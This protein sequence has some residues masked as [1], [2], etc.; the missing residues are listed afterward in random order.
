MLLLFFLTLPLADAVPLP[1]AG[2]YRG[3]WK[4]STGGRVFAAFHGIRYAQPPTGLLRFQDPVLDVNVS[5]I[6]GDVP[7]CIQVNFIDDDVQGDEDCLFLNVY[8][9]SVTCDGM[10]PRRCIFKRIEQVRRLRA[11]DADG[12]RCRRRH[13]QLPSR[14]S[15]VREPGR[16]GI[17][18]RL[19]SQGPEG[20]SRLGHEKHRDVRRRPGF[21]HGRGSQRRG[22][23]SAPPRTPRR[24]IALSG[25]RYSPWGLSD[26]F[27]VRNNTKRLFRGL[28]CTDLACLKRADE[29]DLILTAKNSLYTWDRL[30]L[31]YRPVVDGGLIKTDP[32]SGGTERNFSLLIGVT[33]DEADFLSVFLQSWD[34]EWKNTMFRLFLDEIAMVDRM[35]GPEKKNALERIDEFYWRRGPDRIVELVSDSSFLFPATAEA[36]GHKGDLHAFMFAYKSRLPY[37]LGAAERIGHRVAHGD[38]L[39]FLFDSRDCPL[40]D[41]SSYK[42]IST[43][44]TDTIV[45]FIKGLDPGLKSWKE[46]QEIFSVKDALYD[47]EEYKDIDENIYERMHFWKSLNFLKRNSPN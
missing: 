23:R 39:P 37:M 6:E 46:D 38:E 14:S 43:R 28:N 35:A 31:P 26:D 32:W 44:L 16:A 27:R 40:G 22:C 19:R 33:R 41:D 7:E 21:N 18:G 4:K 1:S 15:R 25:T 12:P 42:D 8:S 13:V 45:R 17:T 30:L 20:R 5:Q 3:S 47:P 11:A 2:G 24:C 29:K 34:D 36:I 9:P 10:D